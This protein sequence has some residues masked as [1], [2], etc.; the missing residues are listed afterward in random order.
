MYQMLFL[1]VCIHIDMP[2]VLMIILVIRT[3]FLEGAGDGIE[4]YIGV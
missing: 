4:F 2:V 1:R 3:P